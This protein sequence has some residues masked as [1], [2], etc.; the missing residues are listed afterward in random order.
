MLVSLDQ[1]VTKNQIINTNKTVSRQSSLLFFQFEKGRGQT[2]LLFVFVFVS[3]RSNEKDNL[4]L[5]LIDNNQ[6]FLLN[7]KEVSCKLSCAFHFQ[8][9][10]IFRLLFALYN[11]TLR[12]AGLAN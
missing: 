10:F 12:L 1:P 5:T 9:L 6:Q 11:Q 2:G 8:E 3:G 4:I 7:F